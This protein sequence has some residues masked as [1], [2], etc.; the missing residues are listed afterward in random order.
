MTP[1]AQEQLKQHVE[2]IAQILYEDS[3]S[4]SINS[5]EA[6]ETTIREKT[7]EYITPEMGVFF[8]EKS[9]TQMQEKSER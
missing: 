4:E 1:E 8:S 7:L 2:A 3:S 5:L 9:P 6:I